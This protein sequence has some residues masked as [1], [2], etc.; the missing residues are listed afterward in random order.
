MSIFKSTW[1]NCRFEFENIL[2]DLRKKP[3]NLKQ[4]LTSFSPHHEKVTLASQSLTDFTSNN[5]LPRI[6]LTNIACLNT[7][8][9]PEPVSS[10][11]WIDFHTN[12][13]QEEEERIYLISFSCVCEWVWERVGEKVQGVET[14]Q[15]FISCR[16]FLVQAFQD[17]F[18]FIC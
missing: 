17:I 15:Y 14:H 18:R 3:E 8:E 11:Q 1:N 9:L 2:R 12:G 5:W 10:C 16:I 13:E 6:F 7:G 4:K